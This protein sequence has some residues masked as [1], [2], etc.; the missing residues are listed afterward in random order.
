MDRT[1]AN[2]IGTSER[3]DAR[4]NGGRTGGNF[5]GGRGGTGPEITTWVQQTFPSSTVGGRTVYD[6][7]QPRS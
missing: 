1:G 3:G 6:L 7:T 5:P 2:G 4:E